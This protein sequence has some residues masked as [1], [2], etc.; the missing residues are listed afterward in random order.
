MKDVWM[1]LLSTIVVTEAMSDMI[2]CITWPLSPPF[3]KEDI[4]AAADGFTESD[5]AP[6][7]FTAGTALLASVSY[8]QS[9]NWLRS[10]TRSTQP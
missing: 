5:T 4:T 8:L 7:V 9:R 1:E 10:L 3:S 2:S 6:R